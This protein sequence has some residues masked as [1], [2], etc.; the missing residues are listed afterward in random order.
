[1]YVKNQFFKVLTIYALISE[2]NSDRNENIGYGVSI[3]IH[4]KDSNDTS[5]LSIFF[6][7][8]LQFLVIQYNDILIV[9]TKS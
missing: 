6:K 8:K 9:I 3:V 5:M 2:Y 1:M 7:K 4:S